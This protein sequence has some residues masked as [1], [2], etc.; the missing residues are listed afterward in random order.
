MTGSMVMGEARQPAGFAAVG[1]VAGVLK[2]AARFA[3]E[4]SSGRIGKPGLLI[5][6]PGESALR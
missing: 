2:I 4:R 1:A 5:S 3:A 6:V